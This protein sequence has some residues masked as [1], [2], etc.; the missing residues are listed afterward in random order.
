MGDTREQPLSALSVKHIHPLAR[1]IRT[2]VSSLLLNV[3]VLS[4]CQNEILG[5]IQGGRSRNNPTR[6]ALD[7]LYHRLLDTALLG[8]VSLQLKR[9]SLNI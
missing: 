7:E 2:S 9:P 6:F 3:A 5:A 8:T 1:S 4:L